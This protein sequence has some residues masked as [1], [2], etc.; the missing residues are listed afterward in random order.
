MENSFRTTHKSSASTGFTKQIMPILRIL[1]YNDSLVTWTVVSLTA[2]KFKPLIFS[3][4]TNMSLLYPLGMYK[5]EHSAILRALLSK[6]RC[7]QSYCLAMG[8]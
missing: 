2:E 3:T 6:D 4:S 5:K 8:L 7:L 1:C